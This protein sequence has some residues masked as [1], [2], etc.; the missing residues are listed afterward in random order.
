[1]VLLAVP[2]FAL[3]VF[4]ESDI[5]VS[6]TNEMTASGI[7]TVET[8]D[9]PMSKARTGAL[10]RATPT[11]HYPAGAM[12]VAL[13]RDGRR[14][15][16]GQVADIGGIV[17]VPVQR[18]AELFGSFKTTYTEATEEVRITGKN[19][20]IQVRVG[21]PYITVNERIFYT[22]AAVLSL[23]GWIFVP[24][25]AMSR[26]MG[27]K[28]TIRKGYYEAYITSGD[29][30]AIAWADDYYN[31]ND[32]YW[33]SRIISAE[34]RGESFTGQIAVGNVVLNRVRSSQFPNNVQSVI[35]DKKYGPQFAP[36]SSGTIYNAP[37]SS[38]IRAAKVCLEGYSLSNRILYFYN[39][40]TAG[41]SW[42]ANN[43]PYIMTIGNH[44]FYG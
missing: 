40:R 34:A 31:E 13:Y 3:P 44:K 26:A 6:D 7:E 35:F 21:D 14:V 19:L 28:V 18:F 17:Y 2:S 37:S 36:V 27:A 32:L 1:M 30:G 25:S 8:T 20:S 16:R 41:S 5:S 10:S 11:I 39:P 43:R 4:G 33:L 38:A 24:L 23:R 22:G 15:L 42:I 12:A 9:A 29:P